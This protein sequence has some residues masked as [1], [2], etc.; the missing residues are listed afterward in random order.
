MFREGGAACTALEACCRS[1]VLGLDA[2][3][4][5]VLTALRTDATAVVL[6]KD[7]MRHCSF[8]PL[9][10]PSVVQ[11]KPPSKREQNSPKIPMITKASSVRA[12]LLASCREEHGEAPNMGRCPVA[13]EI[14]VHHPIDDASPM[15]HC[16]YQ[17]DILTAKRGEI[18]FIAP[19]TALA[20]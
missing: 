15:R 6:R 8:V 10:L 7:G 16:K 9:G 20:V 12:A 1:A 17:Q 19:D 3:P 13:F 5:S 2:P 4:A 11:A 18:F 14:P